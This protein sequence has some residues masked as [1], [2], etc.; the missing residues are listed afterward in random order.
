MDDAHS[1][2]I[3]IP[4]LIHPSPVDVAPMNSNQTD[5]LG[6]RPTKLADEPT[7]RRTNELTNK[8]TRLAGRRA[9]RRAGR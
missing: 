3:L 1:D 4:F 5:Q 8:Q 7:D 9:G 2:S 6:S